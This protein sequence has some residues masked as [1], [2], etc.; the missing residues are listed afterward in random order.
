VRYK[1]LWGVND[2]L[3][4]EIPLFPIKMGSPK[5]ERRSLKEGHLP[6]RSQKSEAG[7]PQ[8]ITSIHSPKLEGSRGWERRLINPSVT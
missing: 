8:G 6:R 3:C 7:T 1:H 4:A 5:G 2:L